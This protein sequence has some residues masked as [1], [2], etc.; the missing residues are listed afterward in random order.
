MTRLDETAR[1]VFPISATPF[2][3][4]GALDLES[5]DR[6]VDFYLARR[7]HGL[8]LL[9]IMGEAPKLT[10][11]E[12]RAVVRRALARVA[13][14]VP[15]VVGVSSANLLALAALANDAMAAGA[16]GVMVAPTPGIAGD[17]ALVDYMASVF[18][19]LDPA[20]PVVYQDYPQ[21]TGVPLTVEAFQRMVDA[22]PRLVMLKHEDCP[23]LTKLGRIR[24]EAARTGRR[25][26]SVL[27]GNNAI[28]YPQELARGAD[29]AM[30][31]FSYPEMLVE[32]YER[33]AAGDAEGAEDVF[34]VYLPL[35]R[36]EAQP[37]TG[38]AVR[39]EL[40]FRRGALASPAVR[41]PGLT[42]TAE[43]H[44]E[45]DGLVA[46]G[47]VRPEA[48]RER[49][50]S[51]VLARECRHRHRGNVPRVHAPRDLA[52]Q[53]VAV[54][55]GH[56]DVA[57]DRVGAG[58]LE[59][60]E[61]ALRRL[62]DEHPRAAELEHG[63]HHLAGVFIVLDDEHGDSFELHGRPLY[64]IVVPVRYLKCFS[65][66]PWTRDRWPRY[67]GVGGSW[68]EIATSFAIGSSS[69]GTTSP[70]RRPSAW[71][72]TGAVIDARPA[73]TR[74]NADPRGWTDWKGS[75]DSEDSEGAEEPR[76]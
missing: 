70:V 31:G 16:A 21:S 33:F 57:D 53:P 44:R 4:D 40:L 65:H 75:E 19:A 47:E 48:G 22:F 63:A 45:I 69:T 24:A 12:S 7:V 27:V 71:S 37:G 32:V 3:P 35:L 56:R 59:C 14:R 6:L 28:Y 55:A 25:R 43:D 61:A 76:W 38:L 42:L 49:L 9:G 13:G 39:K 54:L 74:P 73:W 11:E 41:T 26:V 51:R 29:G 23:G 10:P 58:P 64:T 30:T 8:T 67:C 46:R 15:V 2:S 52:H 50:V 34:D 68:A 60:L 1:G 20:T 18:A 62:R 5:L 17:D 36:Y 72:S 66:E